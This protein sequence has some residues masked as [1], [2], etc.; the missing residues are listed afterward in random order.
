MSL[1]RRDD[2]LTLSDRKQIDGICLA[3]ED[4]WL[5]G[6]RPVV[7]VYLRQAQSAHQPA[8]L[9]ELL[10][11][12]LDYRRSTQDEPH[13]ADYLARFP[14]GAASVQ[15]AFQEALSREVLV[16]H[17][18]GSLIGRYR[19][20]RTLGSGAFAA[21]YLAWDEQLQ[22]EVAVKVPHPAR[23][24]DASERQRFV[25]E[26]RAV[27]RLKH[28]RI[29]AL[30]DAA[31]LADGTV[32]LVMQY[33]AGQSLRQALDHG[34]MPP[35]QACCILA[36]VADA[37]D[38]AH[39]AG[40][41]HRDL[42]PSNILLDEL[43]QPHVCDFGLALEESQQSERQGEYAGT[44][45]YMAPEQ[46]RGESHQLDGRADIW[47]LG[48][49]LYEMLTGRRPFVGRDRPMLAEQIL[50]RD[51]RPPRQINA[52]LAKSVERVC[53]RCL[54]KRPAHRYP[55]AADVAEDLHIA[56]G[57]SPHARSIVLCGG[58]L[59]IT[60]LLLSLVVALWWHHLHPTDT[61]PLP[62]QGSIEL[63]IWNPAQSRRQGV[64]I[65]DD[66]AV[67]LRPGDQVRLAVELNRPAY[68]YVV[69]FDARGVPAPVHP[70][71]LGDWQNLPADCPPAAYFTL[72][73]EPGTG[74][75]MRTSA[76]GMETLLLLAR[77]APLPADVD[78]RAL[79]SGMRD[80]TIPCRPNAVRFQEG[81]PLPAEPKGLADATD[82]MKRDPVLNRPITINDPLLKLHQELVSRLRPHFELIHA[83][84]FPV[85]GE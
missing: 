6:R 24:G 76:S 82:E 68:A 34:E 39:R 1:L 81:W 54:E 20:R 80:A 60:L 78:L 55:T 45:S 41:I 15:A 17:L 56:A 79:L 74:W 71:R 77:H 26:A 13:I 40:V 28:P 66:Q 46:L 70:W 48:V 61:S 2:S 58:L 72:P 23:L 65:G 52:R 10:L 19:V 4:E 3:F 18:P 42:K 5:A 75:A 22:R 29:V 50:T 32:Y 35:E 36:D 63:T 83:V 73:A 8:L 67:P 44:L 53:L 25:E 14:T 12:E 27:A 9:Q 38:A 16:R 31:E 69:W 33:V 49:I 7:E 43:G 47:A 51:P 37:I 84:S 21:V 64:R 85:Q 11:L 62:L 57:R 59:L 30:Y